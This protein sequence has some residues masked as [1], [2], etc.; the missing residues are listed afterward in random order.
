MTLSQRI[1][2]RQ[3][4]QNFKLAR[5]YATWR[6]AYEATECNKCADELTPI[7]LADKGNAAMMKVLDR[8]DNG[9]HGK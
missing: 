6:I 7:M 3:V 8:H 5:K 9:Q 1:S 4:D 2:Q